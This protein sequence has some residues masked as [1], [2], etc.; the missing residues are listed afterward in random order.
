MLPWLG[1]GGQAPRRVSLTPVWHHPDT[2]T[3]AFLELSLVLPLLRGTLALP[4]PAE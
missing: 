4:G 3:P 1:S 2:T